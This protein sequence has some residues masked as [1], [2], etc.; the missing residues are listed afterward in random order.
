MWIFTETGFVNA[1]ATEP[2]GDELRVRARDIKSLEKLCELGNVQILELVDH[3]FPY[4]VF[5]PKKV[6][7]RWMKQVIASV[8][9]TEFPDRAYEKRGRI[10][11]EALDRV[12]LGI[13]EIL[14]TSERDEI[15]RHYRLERWER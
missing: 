10:F 5:V 12:W 11:A 1:D 8:G 4:R 2:G 3:D 14:D 13:K 7:Q 15:R 6:F 9:Y